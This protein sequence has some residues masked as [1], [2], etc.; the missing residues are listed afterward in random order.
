MRTA[1]PPPVLTMRDWVMFDATNRAP[2]AQLRSPAPPSWIRRI[3]MAL[4]GAVALA[5]AVAFRRLRA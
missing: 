3:G 1:P 5:G 4:G 2:S